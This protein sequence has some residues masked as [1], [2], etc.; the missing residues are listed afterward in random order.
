MPTGED[1]WQDRV[2][3]DLVVTL[4]TMLRLTRDRKGPSPE[5]I[6]AE[7]ARGLAAEDAAYAEAERHYERYQ[8]RCR[9]IRAGRTPKPGWKA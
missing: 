4:M 8:A 6:A 5:Q 2:I 1:P 7:E 3:N 9:D